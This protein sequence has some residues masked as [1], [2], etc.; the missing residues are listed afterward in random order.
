M[1][2]PASD[3]PYPTFSTD[4]TGIEIRSVMLSDDNRSMMICIIPLPEE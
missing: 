1:A 3:H 2:K 4:R